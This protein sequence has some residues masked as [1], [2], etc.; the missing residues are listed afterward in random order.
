[1]MTTENRFNLIDEPWIPV[2]DVGRVSLRQLFD[3]PDY[4]ALGG[5]PVQKIAVT[6]LL[7]AIAQAAATPADDEAWNEIG[8][9]GM[10]QACL[11]YL[12]RWHDRFWLYGEQPFLQ[13]PALEG[14]RLLSY[15]AVL[16]DIATGNTTVLTESQVEKT[17]SDADRAV[18]LVT[19]TGFGLAGKKA[20]NSVVLTPGYTGKT[21]PNGKPTSGHAGALIG[22]MGYLHSF[23]HTERLRNTLW[24]NLFSQIQLDTLSFYPQGLGVPPWEEM[25]AGEDCPHA[26]RLK[27]SLMGRL[28]P[29]SHFCLLRDDGLHYSEGITH[30]AYKEGGIDPSVAI[31]LST[32]TPKVLWVDTEKRPWRQLTAILSFMAQTGKG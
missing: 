30:G 17:L 1:M 32:K 24:L 31:N 15:G 13:F 4:R 8:A 5:N 6:K 26:R 14:S 12:E 20:D 21:K 7:L 28:V 11:D 16:P 18:L 10:A 29:L 25:P 27:E 23:L 19:L 3:N 2:V 22:F 9:D